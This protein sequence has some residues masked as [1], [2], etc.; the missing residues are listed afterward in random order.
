[1]L[2]LVET[3]SIA[4]VAPMAAVDRAGSEHATVEVAVGGVVGVVVGEAVG[5]T[6]VGVDWQA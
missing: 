4:T 1:M 3:P 5:G 6:K 2:M